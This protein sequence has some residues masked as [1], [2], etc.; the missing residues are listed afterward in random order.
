MNFINDEAIFFRHGRS[1]LKFGLISLALKKNDEILIPNYICD[2]IPKTLHNMQL[3]PIYYEIKKNFTPDLESIKAL[4]SRN[5]KALI[6]VHYF[7]L[8]VKNNIYR[9]LCIDNNLFFIEDNAHGFGSTIEKKPIGDKSHFTFVSPWK[10]LNQKYG[11]ILLMKNNKSIKK[12][13]FSKTKV[14][15][16][17]IIQSFLK[18]YL[19]EFIYFRKY[20]RKQPQ[21]GVMQ[22]TSDFKVTDELLD[23]WSK[24]RIIN[25]EI[26]KSKKNRQKIFSFWYQFLKKNK[27][28]KFIFKKAPE[29][30]SPLY[31]PVYTKTKNDSIKCF[32]W[33]WNNGLNVISWPSLPEDVIKNRKDLVLRWEKLV[34][35]PIEYNWSLERLKIII[36]K[37]TD[38]QV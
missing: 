6:L 11:A 23:N 31:F 17:L 32:N 25:C 38:L 15:Y 4:L 28:L 24:N 36:S 2:I 16:K 13:K 29:G 3:K 14:D 37:S 8:P 33:G 20:L 12:I 30:S 18:S 5:T 35:F 19:R 21:Y 34:F 26:N 1:A 7:G 27:N 22:S 10:S 9:N